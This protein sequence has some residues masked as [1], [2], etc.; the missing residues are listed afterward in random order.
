MTLNEKAWAILSKD[1]K[2]ALSLQYGMTKSSWESGEIMNKSHYKYLEIKYRAEFFLKTFTEHFEIFEDVIPSFV[3]GDNIAITYFR[4]CLEK[5]VKPMEA[6]YE[7][8]EKFGRVPKTILN[9]KIIATLKKWE[10]EDNAYNKN[11][12]NL[13]KE[14]DRWNNFR[15]LPKEVQ[16]PSAFKRRVK[17]SYKKQIKTIRSIHPLA[18]E[19]LKKLYEAK[20]SPYL[21]LPLLTP[22]IEI[23]K[24][25]NNQT[26]SKVFDEL[27]LYTFKNIDDARDYSTQIFH[28]IA[29]G[30]KEC[31]DGLEFWP[32]YREIIKKATNYNQVMK[33]SSSRKHLQMAMDK[34]KLL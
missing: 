3:T 9:T 5:R 33:I 17:N 21:Y 12:L 1:E 26:S 25:K 6:I 28:Y 18:L 34:F 7:I 14:F 4:I 31:I 22:K 16:E 11:S 15:I 29:K 27:G 8:T 24:V 10:N 20:G 23:L 13:V 32:K 19:K 30:K 2:M